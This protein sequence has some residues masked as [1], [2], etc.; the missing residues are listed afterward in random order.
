[1]ASD[2]TFGYD[3]DLDTIR[4]EGVDTIR[5]EDYDNWHNFTQKLRSTPDWPD[6]DSREERRKL[7]K[8]VPAFQ[9]RYPTIRGGGLV[10]DDIIQEFA[11]Q[12]GHQ[13][14]SSVMTYSTDI[15]DV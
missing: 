2:Q 1:M 11:R 7:A 3:I 10:P 9:D 15:F 4:E 5:E 8:A 12:L 14:Q 13:R 6:A